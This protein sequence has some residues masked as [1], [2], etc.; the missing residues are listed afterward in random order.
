VIIRTVELHTAG[1]PVRIVVDGLPPIHGRTILDKRRYA[2]E[3]LD[4]LR[5]ALMTEPRG[6]A[7]MYGVWPVEPD[8]DGAD[9][10]VLFLHNEG[11]S[12]MCG[13]AT[14]ALGRYAV[15]EGLVEVPEAPSG[16]TTCVPVRLQVP[17]GPVDVLVEVTDGQVG[18]VRFTSVPA[19]A[20][21]L[22]V[23][24]QVPDLG[25]V[26]LD[27]A[28]GG[29]FYAVVT[30]DAIGVEIGVTPLATLVERADA[31]T[32]ATRSV[33]SL[34]HPDAD[35]LAF[36]YGTIVVDIPDTSAPGLSRNICVFA[37][38]QVDRS[39][40]GSGVTARMALRHAR[41]SVTSGQRCRFAG[42]TGE[43]FTATVV[44]E[45]APGVHAPVGVAAVEVEVAG[46]A[47]RTGAN[48]F[49]FD[50]EDPLRHGFLLR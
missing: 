3:H 19:F 21:A 22:D 2:R 41:G 35:D 13:H 7:D 29:A 39:P 17:C 20:A 24:V 25:E 34:E 6:H 36:L 38:R 32:R 33:T 8:L 31:V 44:A 26:V 5:Q 50:D 45:H 18:E 16:T 42:I 47:Y 1:E 48:T 9:M 23:V 10:A 37:D 28:Y 46:H 11:F 27:V 30:A 43:E 15:E 49:T 4:G 14:I 40:T 12:T